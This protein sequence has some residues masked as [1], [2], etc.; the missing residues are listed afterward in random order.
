LKS[1]CAAAGFSGEAVGLL[2]ELAKKDPF[3]WSISYLQGRAALARGKPA[4]A[5]ALF[6][7]VYNEVPG[8]PAAQLSLAVA[9]EL[10][11]DG[12]MAARLYDLT[13][14]AD[15]SFVSASFGLARCLA[16]AGRRED[17]A[18]ACGRVAPTSSLYAQAQSALART[19]IREAPTP[20]G[21]AELRRAAEVLDALA[22]QGAEDAKLRAEVLETAL[23]LLESRALAEDASVLMF[24]QPLNERAVR[25]LLEG[26]LRR[27]AKLEGDRARQI[28]LVDRANRV[29]P[30][31]WV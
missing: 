1:A 6:N 19:L 9:A 18:A 24:G 8:E 20:P 3:D 21:A 4:A 10:A 27:L 23:R 7:E 11:G 16:A 15:P 14:R 29:R 22:L 30:V 12:A 25:R 5:Q 31:T 17:A 26:T 13:S 2:D 28:E